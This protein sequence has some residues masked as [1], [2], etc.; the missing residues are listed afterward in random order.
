VESQYDYLWVVLSYLVAVM[1][2]YVALYLARAAINDSTKHPYYWLIAGAVSMGL[3]IWSTHFIGMLAYE[4]PM[5]IRYAPGLTILSALVALAAAA[6][7]FRIAVLGTDSLPRLLLGGG[8]MG[9]GV[10]AMHYIGMAAMVMPATLSYDVGLATLSVVIAVVTATIALAL[11]VRFAAR[12]SSFPVR[13]FSAL[14]MG[15]AICGMHYT[16]MASATMVPDAAVSSIPAGLDEDS[17]VATIVVINLFTFLLGLIA[18]RVVQTDSIRQR[19]YLL[20]ATMFAV[21]MAAVG[22]TIQQLYQTAYEETENELKELLEVH[23]SL[24]SAV[25]RFD[26]IYSVHDHVDGAAA[27]TLS[28]LVDAH[29]RKKGL[30]RTGEFFI[31]RQRDKE[32]EFVIADRHDGGIAPLPVDRPGMA[33]FRA[34]SN[35]EAGVSLADNPILRRRSIV[36]YRYVPEL[37]VGMVASIALN[38]VRQPFIDAALVAIAL[39]AL[40]ALMGTGQFMAFI[41]PLLQRLRQSNEALEKSVQERTAQLREALQEAKQA[42]IAKSEFVANMSHEIRTPMN[43]VLGMT[44]LLKSTQLTKEQRGLVDTAY[45]SG[46]VLLSLLNDILDF[47]KIEAGKLELETVD[48]DL[49]GTIEEVASLLAE[50]AYRK[51]IE[52]HVDILTDVPRR[53]IG[54]PTRIRQ[55]LTNLVGN[56]IKFTQEGEVVIRVKLLSSEGDQ[57]RLQISVDDTGIGINKDQLA[58]IFESFS[59]ADGSTTRTYGGTG[60]GL[61]ISRQLVGMM[62]GTLGVESTQ[63]VGSRFWFELPLKVGHEEVLRPAPETGLKGHRILVVDDNATNRAILHNILDNWHVDHGVAESGPEAIEKMEQAAAEGQ[64]FDLLLVDMMMPGMDGVTLA[65]EIEARP[66]IAHARK[67]LLTS[68]SATVDQQHCQRLGIFAALR[69]PIKQ[70]QLYEIIAEALSDQLQPARSDQTSEERDDAELAVVSDLRILV[71][72]DNRVN[73]KVIRGMLKKLGY[74]ADLVDN[75]QEAIEAAARGDYD[76][77]LMDCQMPVK[78]GYEA[79]LEIR[80][81]EQESGRH[82]PIIALTANA[83]KGD[84]QKCLAS[85]MDDYIA[86]PLNLARLQQLMNKWDKSVASAR[87]S[88]PG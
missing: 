67:L 63:G 5:T 73:Q 33:L 13:F 50:S 45:S 62:G 43:G 57:F 24:L 58:H 22:L 9:L 59:Q 10:S 14:V 12:P 85:G 70:S 31:V 16:G 35:G 61:T 1:G 53:A 29:N 7:A 23:A 54:D 11:F 71:A 51:H 37:N 42:S 40:L 75:G 26:A 21:V 34:A 81:S 17:L 47:S 74:S 88:I 25:A 52:L 15:G 69:K 56:A 8:L 76:L 49:V 38:E 87:P 30:G 27:A 46:E 65:A 4:V 41:S 6:L 20:I 18:S 77:L 28:Q 84:E 64:A 48:F 86:K 82:L 2:A 83:M 44:E 60:L 72:E 68:A 32:I 39:A 78:D 80:R 79:T 66:A 3:G 36:A 55:V 19:V